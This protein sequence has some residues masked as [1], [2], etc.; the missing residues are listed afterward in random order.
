MR[1]KAILLVL[2]GILVPAQFS[3]S[4]PDR[5]KKNFKEGEK[6]FKHQWKAKD[7][8]TPNGD[9]LGPMFNEKSCAKCHPRGGGGGRQFNVQLLSLVDRKGSKSRKRMIPEKLNRLMPFFSIDGERTVILHRQSLDE[10]YNE[11]RRELLGLNPPKNLPKSRE[12]LWQRAQEKKRAKLPVTRVIDRYR[13]FELVISE[14]NTPALFGGELIDKIPDQALHAI[15]R[16]Q[17]RTNDGIS[18]RV[19]VALDGQLGK[20]GW[21]GQT[22]SLASFVEGACAA[23]LGLQSKTKL[24]S[25]NPFEPNSMLPGHDMSDEQ[26][27][28]LIH[29]VESI[30]RPRFLVDDDLNPNE[31]LGK[32]MFDQVACSKCHTENVGG[33]R[34]LYSDLLLHDMGPALADPLPALPEMK[35]FQRTVL[36]Q[37]GGY[38][39]SGLFTSTERRRELTTNILQEW[40]T[41]PLWGVADSAPYMHDGRAPTLL[42]AILLHG[43]EAQHS[44]RLFQQLR[45]S[46]QLAL[47]AFL[48]AQTARDPSS[49]ICIGP[50]GGF[51]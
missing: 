3:W 4:Q 27:E 39:G 17:N 42:D 46:Q 36:H 28:L 11:A 29:F 18:G 37:G 45:R 49:P 8:L 2:I 26:L 33:V 44:V 25:Q 7:P 47:L 19:S 16:E 5:L 15:A 51:H 13:D 1:N 22:S 41:P 6:L 20:F 10:T 24:Q 40:R 34:G 48:K 38:F 50:T 9:G 31:K 30:E 12:K 23:E 35:F 21:R 14:R 32:R 43:G